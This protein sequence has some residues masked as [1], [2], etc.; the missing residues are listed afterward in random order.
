MPVSVAN[1]VHA[2]CLEKGAFVERVRLGGVASK[3]VE[4]EAL[5]RPGR[6][7]DPARRP[8][9]KPVRLGQRAR[10]LAPLCHQTV[11]HRSLIHTHWQVL[12]L[13]VPPERSAQPSKPSS[14]FSHPL[15]YKQTN[16]L[17]FT[18]FAVQTNS[19]PLFHTPCGTNKLTCSFSLPLWYKQTNLL[20]FTPFVVQTNS[21]PLFHTL[22]GTNKQACSFSHPLWYKQ[23]QFL[24]FHTICGNPSFHIR[25]LQNICSRIQG[26]MGISSGFHFLIVPK[27]KKFLSRWGC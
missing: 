6:E 24:F 11:L 25:H 1:G 17:F 2:E 9:C 27:C 22:C 21:L 5:L 8:V 3:V 13:V 4:S 15:W 10:V 18:P 20:F 14:S 16:L 26:G 7:E 12:V 23:T 19:L